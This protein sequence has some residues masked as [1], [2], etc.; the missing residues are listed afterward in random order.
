MSLEWEITKKDERKTGGALSWWQ[1]EKWFNLRLAWDFRSK[2]YR[3]LNQ[4]TDHYKWEFRNY[5]TQFHKDQPVAWMQSGLEE[6]WESEFVSLCVH[7]CKATI[8][9]LVVK[10]NENII[11]KPSSCFCTTKKGEEIRNK[12]WKSKS[13]KWKHYFYFMV[14]AVDSDCSRAFSIKLLLCLC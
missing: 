7:M 2:N 5:F 9:E 12:V 6:T 3:I 13:V 10:N 8:R 4:G 1:D 11:L 14:I